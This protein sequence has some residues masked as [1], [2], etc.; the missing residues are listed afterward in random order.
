MKRF[1][2]F[3][4]VNLDDVEGPRIILRAPSVISVEQATE[5]RRNIGEALLYAAPSFV[6]PG[7]TKED[8][9]KEA[10]RRWGHQNFEQLHDRGPIEDR[11]A[12]AGALT[13]SL[14]VI[15]RYWV[16]KGDHGPI[17]GNGAS[18]EEAFDA[19]ALREKEVSLV[20]P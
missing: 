6:H 15:P 3:I 14:L 19:A 4:S 2:P 17:H 11:T 1:G 5:L 13:R 10:F 20:Q 18:W 8:A 7:M 9:E 16:G 12:R